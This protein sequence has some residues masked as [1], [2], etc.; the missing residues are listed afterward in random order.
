MSHKLIHVYNVFL[1]HAMLNKIIQNIA[2]NLG[3]INR[4]KIN[5]HKY[6]ERQNV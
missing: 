2:N 4:K 6:V 3:Y 5:R 1:V